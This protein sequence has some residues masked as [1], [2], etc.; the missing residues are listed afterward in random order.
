[1]R[2]GLEPCKGR[3]GD[4][5]SGGDGNERFHSRDDTAYYNV[6]QAPLEGLSK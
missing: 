4:D 1:V 2:H 3:G 6:I 5:Q